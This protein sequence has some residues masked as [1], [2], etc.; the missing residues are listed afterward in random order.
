MPEIV[1][2]GE[3]GFLVGSIDEAV[4]AGGASGALHGRAVRASV[5]HRFD[6]NR[7]ADDYV[8]LYRRVVHIDR[9]RRAAERAVT[10]FA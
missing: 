10:P 4:G 1:R 3:N 2:E 6:S 5:E 8:A 7:V 9:R